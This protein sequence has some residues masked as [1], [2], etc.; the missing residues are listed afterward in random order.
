MDFATVKTEAQSWLLDLPA[1]MTAKIGDW[2]NQAIKDAEKRHNFR[3]MESNVAPVPIVTVDKQRKLVD[4]PSDWKESRGL[5]YILFQD[6]GNKEIDW[7]G[8]ESEMV[9]TFG[10]Q[11][12]QETSTA[13]D[14]EGEPQYLLE[15]PTQIDVYPLP[16]NNSAWTN[17]LHRVVVPYWK[18]SAALVQDADNNDW[19]ND[20]EYY[21][22]W[23]TIAIG[24]SWAEN[25]E[26]AMV[27]ERK[28]ER[29]FQTFKRHDQRSQLPDRIQLRAKK[30]ALQGRARSRNPS[31]W[32][33][34]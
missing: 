7:A 16:D 1:G 33:N 25:E 34:V 3:F 13:P 14:D 23:K 21:V 31:R 20:A 27:F 5:P 2:V 26:R 19:T 24:F 6:G 22:I 18:F 15:Q 32:E 17:G 30:G 29:E 12:A 28:A 4:K 11:I 10:Y 9:R 8:S